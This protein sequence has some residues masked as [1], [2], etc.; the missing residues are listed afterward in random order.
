[1][2]CRICGN[3]SDESR[4]CKNCKYLLDN[5]SDEYTIRR[6]LSDDKTKKV[7]EENK[8][9]AQ[10]LADTYY[11]SVLQGYK[12]QI[13]KDS[14]ENFGYNTFTDGI[15]LGLDIIIP[16]ANE[17][18]QNKIKEKIKNMIEIRKKANKKMKG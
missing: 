14:K 8:K 5:G 13:M 7:W 12:T 9:I 10:D 16:L 11:D 17:E 15:N 4:L 6:M 2:H 1:M 3:K 18:V